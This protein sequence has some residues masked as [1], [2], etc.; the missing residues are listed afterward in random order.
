VGTGNSQRWQK[1]ER[2]VISSSSQQ[3]DAEKIN[4]LVGTPVS[5]SSSSSSFGYWFRK[6]YVNKIKWVEEREKVFHV[7]MPKRSRTL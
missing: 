4:G 7:L 1:H 3:Q 6:D 5:I 2:D